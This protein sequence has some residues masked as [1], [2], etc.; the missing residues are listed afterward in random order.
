MSVG[1]DYNPVTA[2]FTS[3]SVGLANWHPLF[4]DALAARLA[5]EI[6]SAVVGNNAGL[7][8]LMNKL[9]N[10]IGEAYRL[11]IIDDR[12]TLPMLEYG[13]NRYSE[14]IPRAAGPWTPFGG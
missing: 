4:N 8:Y 10:T 11:G 14:D 5:N 6:S 1:C 3:R 12:P 2:R 9:Q 13:W 7:P